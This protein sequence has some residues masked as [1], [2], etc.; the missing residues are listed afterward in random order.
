M[1]QKLVTAR[2]GKTVLID[3]DSHYKLKAWSTHNN[4]NIIEATKLA[5]DLLIEHGTKIVDKKRIPESNK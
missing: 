5:I 3:K 2:N 1:R 4:M